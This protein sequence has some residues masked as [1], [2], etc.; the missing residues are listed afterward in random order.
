MG[1]PRLSK[2][3]EW[4][5]LQDPQDYGDSLAALEMHGSKKPT[6][7]FRLGHCVYLIGKDNRGVLS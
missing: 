2:F 7:H 1:V 4:L 3:L 5:I 6:L